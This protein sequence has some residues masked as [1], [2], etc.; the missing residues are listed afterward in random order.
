[1]RS[2]IVLVPAILAGFVSIPLVQTAMAQNAP[3][4]LSLDSPDGGALTPQLLAQNTTP[5]PA[6]QVSTPQSI[7]RGL[8]R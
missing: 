7:G 1:M 6:Q 8:F 5:T 3:L 4:S 2:V